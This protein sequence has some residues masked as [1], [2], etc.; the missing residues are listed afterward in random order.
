MG[1]HAGLTSDS[2]AKANVLSNLLWGGSGVQTPHQVVA[3]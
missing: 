2:S 3:K 1:A